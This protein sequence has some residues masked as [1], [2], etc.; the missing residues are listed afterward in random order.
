MVKNSINKERPLLTNPKILILCFFLVLS[1]TF[2]ILGTK[3]LLDKK[4]CNFKHPVFA[5]LGM[6][7]G[8]Y[9]NYILFMLSFCSPKWALNH[10]K[11]NFMTVK[12]YIG[13]KF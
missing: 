13:S 9:L 11:K 10:R 7:F 6:F 3:L 12:I 2:D 4:F 5:N 1:G 8:E